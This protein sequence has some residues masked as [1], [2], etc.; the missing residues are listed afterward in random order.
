M[1]DTGLIEK[2]K[3]GNRSYFIKQTKNILPFK[4]SKTRY[5]KT[6][7]F[8]DLLKDNL[9][10]VKNRIRLCF[11]HGS[12][13]SGKES[14]DNDIDLFIVEDLGIRDLANMLSESRESLGIQQPKQYPDFM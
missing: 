1:E 2:A 9:Q 6:V 7:L 8:G 10:R 5:L 14:S 12:T 3:S 11:V 4:T 13:A